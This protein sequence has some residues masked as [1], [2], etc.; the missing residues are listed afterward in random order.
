MNA[1]TRNEAEIDR[2]TEQKR[3]IEEAYQRCL[4][5]C[6]HEL[7]QFAKECARG[8]G[9]PGLPLALNGLT[10][11]L[12]D[13]QYDSIAKLD[14]MIANASSPLAAEYRKQAVA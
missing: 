5:A 12:G 2:C 3:E 10:D 8:G 7:T 9:N 1:I 11:I 14:R 13:M 4:A 6:T